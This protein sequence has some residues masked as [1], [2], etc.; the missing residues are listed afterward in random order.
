MGPVT[1]YTFTNVQADH[2]IRAIFEANP[3]VTFTISASAGPGGTIDP[4]GDEVVTQGMWSSYFLIRADPH[5]HIVDVVV[6][7]TISLGV[8]SSYQFT[9]VQADHTIAASFALDTFT[10]TYTADTGGT[11]SAESSQ[12]SPTAPTAAR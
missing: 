10:L 9:D 4:S 11:I 7:G 8:V 2:Y 6:D 5:Y 1:S 3:P 12:P